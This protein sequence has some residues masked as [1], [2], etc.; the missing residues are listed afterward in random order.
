MTPD[1]FA[2][3]W[4]RR[5]LTIGDGEPTEPAAVHWIQWG[6]RFLDLRAPLAG[7]PVPPLCGPGLFGGITTWAEPVLT[8]HHEFDS[9]PGSGADAGAVSWEDGHLVERGTATIS[10]VPTPYVE[11]WER[12]TSVLPAEGRA[13]SPWAGASVVEADGHRMAG[14]VRP[15]GRWFGARS[16]RDDDG[17]WS[18]VDQIGDL[19]LLRALRAAL[20]RMS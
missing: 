15:D 9:D 19:E 7:E 5:S 20:L 14:V 16:S 10:G 8:W 3:L 11:V 12:I 2:G 6:D 4:R 1:A 18:I 13:L 17:C